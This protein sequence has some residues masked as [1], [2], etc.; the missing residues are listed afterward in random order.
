MKIEYLIILLFLI[1]ASI[2]CVNA[3][4]NE[5]ISADDSKGINIDS[6]NFSDLQT[7]IDN[8]ND[9]DVLYLNNQTFDLSEKNSISINKNIV[10]NGGREED[11]IGESYSTINL[12]GFNRIFKLGDNIS[13]TF[14]DINFINIGGEL[15]GSRS[16]Q[17]KESN[18]TF[19]NVNFINFNSFF[20]YLFNIRNVNLNFNNCTF[21]ESNFEGN[22]LIST[23]NS[24]IINN[25]RFFNNY[26][27]NN[28]ILSV[29]SADSVYLNNILI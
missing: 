4:N 15:V 28:G 8:S 16:Y 11:N 14:N 2:S 27:I 6:N 21:A 29:S 1:F 7:S 24:I 19:N 3:T 17:S 26:F 20:D 22:F 12:N 9:N 18:L 13:C 10:I 23:S 5:F 25:S